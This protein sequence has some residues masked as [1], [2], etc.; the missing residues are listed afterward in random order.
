MD[1]Q[2]RH[3]RYERLVGGPE[4]G[5]QLM[6]I[7]EKAKAAVNSQSFALHGQRVTL[8]RKFHV[9]AALEGFTEEERDCYLDLD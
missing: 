4:R 9:M 2:E 6:R 3:E 5:F 7:Y 8:E 1:E